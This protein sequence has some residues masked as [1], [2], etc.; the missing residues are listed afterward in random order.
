[1]G[2][3]EMKLIGVIVNSLRKLAAVALSSLQIP[4]RISQLALRLNGLLVETFPERRKD[5][6]HPTFLLVLRRNNALFVICL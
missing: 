2:H 1:M 6:L 3:D 5:K 4:Y